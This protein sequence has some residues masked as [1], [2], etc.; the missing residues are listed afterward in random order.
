MAATAMTSSTTYIRDIDGFMASL[1]Q[2][3]V[4]LRCRACDLF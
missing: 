4:H 1:L 2:Q 3:P